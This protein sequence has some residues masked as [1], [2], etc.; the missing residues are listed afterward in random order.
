MPRPRKWDTEDERRTAQNERR[1]TSRRI[2]ATTEFVA[3]DGEGIG[4][5]RDH[6]YVLLGMGDM[7]SLENP[8]GLTW[9]AVASYLYTGYLARPE[10]AFVGFYLGYDF[11]QWLRNLPRERAWRLLTDPGIATRKRRI[12]PQLGPFPVRYEDWELDILGMKRLKL[13]PRGE[14]GWMYICDAG[15]FFQCSFLKAINPAQWSD[16][17]VSEAEYEKIREGK[18]RRDSAGL[19]DRMREYNRLENMVMARLM[20]RYEEGLVAAGIHLRKNEWFGPGQAA[21]KWMSATELPSAEVLRDLPRMRRAKVSGMAHSNDS[22]SIAEIARLTY[23]GGWFEIFAH[24]HIPGQSW[25]YDINSAYPFIASKLPCLLHGK[26]SQGTNIPGELG[27][28][29]IRIVY[30]T[31]SGTHLQMGS[32]LHRTPEGTIRR[33]YLTRGYYWQAEIDAGIRCG[34]IDSVNYIEWWQYDPCACPAPMRGL[35]SLYQQRLATG[36]NTPYGKALKLVYNSVYGKLAQSVGNPRYG[37]AIYASLVTSGCRAMILDAIASHPARM[38]AEDASTTPSVKP[39]LLMVATDAVFF[40]SPH[41]NLPLSEKIG[42]WSEIQRNNLTLFKPGI[43]WDDTTRNAITKG[44]DPVYKS[45]GISAGDFA[46]ELCAVDNHYSLWPKSYPAERDP[47]GDRTGWHP[48]I[49]YKS[50]FAMVTCQQ[51]LQRNKWHLAGTLGHE[52][53]PGICDG[54]D[55]NHLIQDADPIQKRHSGWY[56]DGIYWSRPYPDA[57]NGEIESTPYDK[58]FGQPDPDEYGITDDGTVKESWGE[59]FRYTG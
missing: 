57:G 10:A 55:G 31:I 53:K 2:E 29:S 34:A 18:S 45:R 47:N 42:E 15:P 52:P 50:G 59:I 51:A 17:V 20:H 21:Q 16:P 32:A 1:K 49:K 44:S 58:R 27:Q 24:G 9:D 23:Y 33:P 7:D 43:Y 6:R 38:Q 8:A 12:S 56:Q 35:V 26:W 14:K 40:N 22:V 41:T 37:N 54:C 19:D 25:E 39:Y 13:R 11:T 5:G 3:V 48:L 36:K 4:R 46:S 30:A 28:N